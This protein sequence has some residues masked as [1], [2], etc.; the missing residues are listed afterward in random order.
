MD[1]GIFQ[2]IHA[3]FLNEVPQLGATGGSM[4]EW[5]FRTTLDHWSTFLG[6]IFAANFPITSLFFRKLEAQ[7]FRLHVLGKTAVGLGLL[8]AFYFWVTG[9]FMQP[10]LEYNQTNAYFGFIPMIAYIYFR[11]LTPKLRS[12][13]IDLLHQIGKSTLETY[14]MQ[15]HIWLTSNAKSLL[16]LIPGWNKCNT[17]VVTVLYFYISRRL[18]RLT[19]FL[20][21]M[22][23]PDD[24]TKCI[25]S[26]IGIGLIIGLFYAMA[27]TLS[28][29][30]MVTLATVPMVALPCGFLLYKSIVN[31]TWPGFR[32]SF[33]S[34]N[35]G[36]QSFSESSFTY[37]KIN[38]NQKSSF[39]NS[40]VV[41]ESETPASKVVPPFM[42]TMAVLILGLFWSGLAASG[43][44]KIALLPA[45]CGNYVNQGIW[46]PINP[47]NEEEKGS[48]FREYEVSSMICADPS[49]LIF[50][51]G[52][53][54]TNANE[55]CRFSHRDKKSINNQLRGRK[56]VYVGDSMTRNL[57]YASLRQMGVSNVGGYDLTAPKHSDFKHVVDE[58]IQMEFIWAPFAEDLLDVMKDY[59]A[60]KSA[61][62]IITG[63]G[64]WD[65][66][67][68]WATTEDKASHE[69][70]VK[71]L[72]LAIGGSVEKGN[73]VIWFVPT[74]INDPALNSVDK[75]DHMREEHLEELRELYKNRGILEQSSFVLDGSAFTR[76]RVLEAYDGVHYPPQVYGAGAQILF[77]SFDW[78]LNADDVTPNEFTPNKPGKMANT[79]LGLMMLFISLLGLFF[80]D[81]FLGFSY[82][83]SFFVKGVMPFGLYE[84]AFATLHQKNGL[85]VLEKTPAPII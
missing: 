33:H 82:L 18:Y 69:A 21:G 71:D 39:P 31:S 57:Y 20:R 68:K 6:M 81:G 23:L 54:E 50:T 76:E 3:P 79:A 85:P 7:P 56:I 19:L 73:P 2:L 34:L 55:L 1:T 5:Y 24:L 65:R 26:L 14:L 67:H 25:Q 66:L 58:T 70:T 74:T 30:G 53:K 17:L 48:A 37:P 83:A 75:R 12:Y 8:V 35:I 13:S 61:D 16:I 60:Q 84:E 10:K 62:V 38:K 46:I 64:A 63:G 41:I 44:G 59:N 52:W 42:G 28:S 36:D 78:I 32:K 9:P 11:N 27:F 15:H 4:W 47:C 51:W 72:A 40:G 80:F 77:N 22:H 29:F 45:S 43:G 49:N